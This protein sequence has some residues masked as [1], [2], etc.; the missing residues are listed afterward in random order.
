MGLAGARDAPEGRLRILFAVSDHGFGHATRTVALLRAALA[1][2][3]SLSVDLAGGRGSAAMLAASFTGEPRVRLI[4]GPSDPGLLLYP[5]SLR[6]NTPG[7]RA[8]WDRWIAGWEGWIGEVS[9][10]IAGMRAVI[11][12]V[13]P[14]ATLLAERLGVRSALLGNFLWTDT[15]AEHLEAP[16][17]DRLRAAYARAEHCFAY[18]FALGFAGARPPERLPLVARRPT[19][20]RAEIRRSL[21]IG[22]R[23][24]LLWLSGGQSSDPLAVWRAAAASGARSLAPAQIAAAIPGAAAVPADDPEGQDYL[25]AADL[26]VGKVGYGTLSEALVSGVPLVMVLLDRTAET[27]PLVHGMLSAGAGE[28]VAEG[29]DLAP[30]ISRLLGAAGRYERR[31]DGSTEAARRVLAWL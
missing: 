30:A 13:V 6:V 12:D 5:G 4:P 2:E 20:T 15:L 17:L 29:D 16:A 28:A 23:E 22:E 26:V 25:A 11:S 7:T 3:P 9:G 1:L 10:R 19:R 21:G 8:A 27:A 31:E 14:P 18:P 24:P